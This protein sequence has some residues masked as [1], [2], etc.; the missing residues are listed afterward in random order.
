MEPSTLGI[1][2]LTSLSLWTEEKFKTNTSE[3]LNKIREK[4]KQPKTLAVY[5]LKLQ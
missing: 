2:L 5:M 3:D 1:S 4:R